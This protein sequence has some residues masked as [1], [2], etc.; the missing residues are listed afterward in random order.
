MQLTAGLHTLWAG[1]LWIRGHG[2]HVFFT[3]LLL[4]EGW[5]DG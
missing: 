3:V 5:M 2:G 4:T 1:Y